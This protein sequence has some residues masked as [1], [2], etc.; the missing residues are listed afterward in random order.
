MYM[1]IYKDRE[2]EREKPIPA[3]I[4]PLS[5]KSAKHSNTIAPLPAPPS[6]SDASRWPDQ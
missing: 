5:P 3:T 6:F 2:T 4:S 1:Y